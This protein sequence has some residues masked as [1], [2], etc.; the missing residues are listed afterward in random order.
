M[1]EQAGSPLI[2][3]P[4]NWWKTAFDS[5]LYR[6]I[7]PLERGAAVLEAELKWLPEWLGLQPGQTVLDLACGDGR[8]TVPLAAAGYRVIGLDQSTRMLG[9]ARRRQPETQG[10]MDLITGDMRSYQLSRTADAA[11]CVFLSFGM[12]L[13]EPDHLRTLQ[14]VAAALKPGG[15][16]YLEAFNPFYYVNQTQQALNFPEGLLVYQTKLDHWQSRVLTTLHYA[17]T[18][19][20]TQA[21]AL[22]WRAFTLFEM[23]RLLDAAGFTVLQANGGVLEPDNFIPVQSQILGVVAE[24]R[25]EAVAVQPAPV[26]PTE[27]R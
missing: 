27:P 20:P 3:S 1:T 21:L 9:A 23:V 17:R 25:P 4:T 19:K 2:P 18:G 13:D 6:V 10:R 11:C 14:T 12:F 24:R 26:K 8:L 15:R 5:D 22:S 16:L 7:A